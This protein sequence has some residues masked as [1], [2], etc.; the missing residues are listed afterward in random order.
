ME[1]PDPGRKSGTLSWRFA[2]RNR[3]RSSDRPTFSC[4]IRRQTARRE[5]D[6]HPMSSPSS[7]ISESFQRR[8]V[9]RLLYFA[10]ICPPLKRPSKSL[11]GNMTHVVR[12]FQPRYYSNEQLLFVT[13][14]PPHPSSPRQKTTAWTLISS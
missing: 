5:A 2:S 8:Y 13:S 3:R 10:L 9:M 12:S 1:N 6:W 11:L 4:G 14:N 7:S